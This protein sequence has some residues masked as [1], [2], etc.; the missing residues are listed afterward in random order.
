MPDSSHV[1]TG[2]ARTGAVASDEFASTTTL[3]DLPLT[4]VVD[5]PRRKPSKLAYYWHVM[6]WMW[7][8]RDEPN[9]RA[10]WRRMV[11]EIVC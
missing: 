10:K 2:Y 6:R 5:A 4:V 1:R 9:N 3:I 8:H 7:R 11:K